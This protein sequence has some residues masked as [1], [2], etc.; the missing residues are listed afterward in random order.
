MCMVYAPFA[1]W[2]FQVGIA[3]LT[4]FVLAILHYMSHGMMFV[5]M[6]KESKHLVAVCASAATVSAIAASSTALFLVPQSGNYVC[7]DGLGIDSPN[8]QYAE[9]L[10]AAPLLVY[11]AIAVEEKNKLTM[12]DFAMIGFMFWC[13]LF[14]LLMNT[15]TSMS[16]GIALFVLSSVCMFVSMGMVILARWKKRTATDRNRSVSGISRQH[17]GAGGGAQDLQS[18][19]DGDDRTMGAPYDT[20]KCTW[21]LERSQTKSRLAWLLTITLPAFPA[22]Y[23]LCYFG[24]LDRDELVV[25]NMIAGFLTKFAYTAVLSLESTMVEQLQE[26]RV[27]EQRRKF[28]RYIFHEVSFLH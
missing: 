5:T 14:G 2:T 25:G 21:R 1:S 24:L 16:T 26:I 17:S 3:V 18:Q 22:L 13:I 10:V 12:E 9:W 23:L 15:N 20:Y 28:F 19:V 11:I 4:S 7:V 8:S 6:S 27:T